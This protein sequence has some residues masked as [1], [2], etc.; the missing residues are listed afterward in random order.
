MTSCTLLW[1]ELFDHF[2]SLE[3]M[4]LKKSDEIKDKIKTLDT[5]TKAS[6]ASLEERESTMEN[7]VAIALQK[8]EAAMKA[9]VAGAGSFDE[10]EDKPD[11]DDS[12]GLLLKLKSFCVRIDSLGFGGFVSS[13]KKE[14]EMMWDQISVALVTCADPA[15]FVLEA[16]SEVFPV[17]KKKVC[18]NDL[19]WACVL[20]L[21]SLVPVM[22]DPI[23]GKSRVLVTP[24]VKKTTKEIVEQWK[25]SLEHRDGIE[26]MKP[27]DVHTFFRYLL[28]LREG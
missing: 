16:I 1:K 13:R 25:K 28:T 26:T 11:V 19:S 2:T 21:K 9:A 18:M 15:R 12:E 8:V 17:D 20:I 24:S 22:V 27:P 10:K 7:S 5:E 23:M 3:Q 6:L 14:T 4:L